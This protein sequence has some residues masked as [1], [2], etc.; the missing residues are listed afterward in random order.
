M[1]IVFTLCSNNYLAQA[2]I[3]ADS[4]QY[5]NP[6]DKVIIGLVDELNPGIDYSFI[7]SAEIIPV[8]QINIPGLRELC[9]R[10][11]IVEL[12]TIVKASYIK[13][14]IAQYSHTKNIIF[15]DPDVRLFSSLH[16]LYQELD[17]AD[18]L[19]TPHILS[20][21]PDDGFRPQE[22]VFLNY[23][24]YNL[25]F[26]ALRTTSE[27]VVKFLDWWENRIINYGYN[28]VADG[29]FVDQ[30]WVN[31]VPVFYKRVHILQSPGYNMA[32]W[33]LYE[34]FITKTDKGYMLND[35]VELIFYHFSSFNYKEPNVLCKSFYNRFTLEDRPDLQPLYRQYHN[36]MI[37]NKAEFFSQFLC[38]LLPQPKK[39]VYKPTFREKVH[40]WLRMCTPPI[41][42]RFKN[43]FHN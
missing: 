1:N 5:Y 31:L 20:P 41:Y 39:D 28:R 11:N 42:Y 2:K 6:E 34:R 17:Q 36:D 40:F 27:D 25:G 23:G 12:N 8:K 4:V 14:F 10:Y 9:N 7:A 3:F 18:I 15:F 21:T 37:N 19:L 38:S 24:I 35:G 33:N 26:I 32:P 22:N 30:L 13:Y 16:P 29:F 43:N